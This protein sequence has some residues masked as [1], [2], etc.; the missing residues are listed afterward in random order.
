MPSVETVQISLS[1]LLSMYI[2]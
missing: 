1:Y 2:S